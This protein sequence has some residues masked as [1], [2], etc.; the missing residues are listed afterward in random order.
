MYEKDN[1]YFATD[2]AVD[3]TVPAMPEGVKI[4]GETATWDPSE[5]ASYYQYE[6]S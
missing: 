4:E 6:I 5:H 3:G 1:P 2:V